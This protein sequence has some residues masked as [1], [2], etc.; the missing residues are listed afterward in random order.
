MALVQITLKPNEWHKVTI[1]YVREVYRSG[2][3]T[4]SCP[5]FMMYQVSPRRVKGCGLERLELLRHLSLCSM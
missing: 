4:E 3:R 1:S 2:Q 5:Q